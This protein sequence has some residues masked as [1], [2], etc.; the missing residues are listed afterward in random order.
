QAIGNVA[1]QVAEQFEKTGR[2]EKN[3][4]RDAAQALRFPFWDWAEERVV[5][6]GLPPVLSDDEV[7]LSVGSEKVKVPNPLSYFKFKSIPTGFV[8]ITDVTAY[9]AE[10]PR[11]VRYA[12]SNPNIWTSD[13]DALNKSL[14]KEAPSLRSRVAL[15]FTLSDSTDTT[16]ETARTYDEFSN[17]TV[18]STNKLHYYTADSLEGIHDS[19]HN[20][21]GGNGHMANPDYAGFDPIF[22]LHHCNVDRLYAL[23][24]YVYPKDIYIGNGTDYTFTQNTGT[25]A[26]VYNQELLG[27]TEL[28]PFRLPDGNYWTSDHSRYFDAEAY[29]KYYTYPEIVGIKVDQPA[30]DEE[31]EKYRHDLQKYYGLEG[32]N[33]IYYPTSTLNIRLAN[34]PDHIVI[35]V[36]TPEFAFNGPYSVQVHYKA[37]NTEDIY[38][39]SISVFARQHKTNCAACRRRRAGDSS[40]HGLIPVP[41]S[42]IED[43]IEGAGLDVASLGA[44]K[45][46]GEIMEKLKKHLTAVIV[47][48]NGKE[49]GSAKGSTRQV[50][51]HEALDTNFTPIITLASSSIQEA[52]RDGTN[53]PVKWA[54][55]VSHGEIFQPGLEDRGWKAG[56][57]AVVA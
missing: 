41:S 6:E 13:T 11:T 50:A 27:Q 45:A 19:V 14:K 35:G 8:N 56:S 49:L 39:G 42:I 31:R 40:I 16:K 47:D 43:V 10:W 15:L 18:Q 25:Y 53:H 51:A 28:A 4:W 7:T 26:L 44:D 17:H 9:F 38:V 32:K 36:Q 2:F 48:S 24:E 30:T 22:F 21:V 57:G 33:V 46:V 1:E 55:W 34:V 12:P 52:P 37:F 20:V 54:N 5:K 29:P 3:V 23:W